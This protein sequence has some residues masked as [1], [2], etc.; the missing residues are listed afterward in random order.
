MKITKTELLEKLSNL[1]LGKKAPTL[2]LI[3]VLATP[4]L[5]GCSSND[6]EEVNNNPV[7]E[8]I[9]DKEVITEEG[10]EQSALEESIDKAL[11]ADTEV[12]AAI[13]LMIDAAKGLAEASEEAKQSE[14]YQASKEQTKKNFHLIADF[15]FNGGEIEGY[16][17][18]EVSES[19][20]LKAISALTSLDGT[21]EEYIP[22][23]KD[24]AKETMKKF[25]GWLWDKSTDA[26]SILKDKGLKWLDE[27]NEKSNSR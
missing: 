23:Y 24:R 6:V 10:Q 19:T 16:K 17:A 27:T 1:K 21:I 7:S 25:G 15:L 2:A 13:G 3:A 18:S 5:M 12:E 26:G 8:V 20:K 4:G 11:N 14:G 22:E 9:N